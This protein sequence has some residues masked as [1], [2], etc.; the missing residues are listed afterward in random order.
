[1][2]HYHRWLHGEAFP[3]WL[4]EDQDAFEARFCSGCAT[5]QVKSRVLD[6]WVN[7]SMLFWHRKPVSIDF[8]IHQE[9]DT[10]ERN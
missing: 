5:L 7:A 1:M 10:D 6:R 8:C 4:S 9:V 3:S 2:S